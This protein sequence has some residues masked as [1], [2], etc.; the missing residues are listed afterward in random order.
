MIGYTVA[1]NRWWWL[2]CVAVCVAC[3]ATEMDP[4]AQVASESERGVDG[5]GP[6]SPNVPG[7]PFC[8]DPPESFDFSCSRPCSVCV[9]GHCLGP[10]LNP[11]RFAQCDDG[12]CDPCEAPCNADCAEPPTLSGDPLNYDP[13]RPRDR[14][15]RETTFHRVG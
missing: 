6:R 2:A 7:H 5:D 3:G 8:E 15:P 13:A 1:L 9:L 10:E 14:A 12:V 11:D 4:D